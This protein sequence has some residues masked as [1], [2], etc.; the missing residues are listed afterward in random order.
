MTSRTGNVR[1]SHFS[2]NFSSPTPLLIISLSLLLL[3]W[4]TP[5]LADG[6]FVFR[7][8]KAVDINEPTQ[9]AV[10][11]YDQGRED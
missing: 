10:I 2:A 1:V 7:W 5:S 8:N 4:A 3:G 6:C 9:K 11:V